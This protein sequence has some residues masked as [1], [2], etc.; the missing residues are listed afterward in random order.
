M[1]FSDT[2]NKLGIIQACE[3]YTNLGDAGISGV[4]QTLKVFTA[5][6]N[7][8]Q[9][10]VWHT[11]FMSYGGWQ[12][13]DSNQTD[14]PAAVATLT[15]GQTSYAIPSGALTVRGVEIKD[16]SNNWTALQPLTEE[17]I[18][19][20]IYTGGVSGR[21][22]SYSNGAMGSFLSTSGTP[23]YYQMVG[24]S[25]RIFPAANYTQASSFKVFFDRGT[26]A[27]AYTDTTKVP[28]FASEYHGI[29]PIG[30]SIEYLM[31]KQ[32]TNPT[33]GSLNARYQEF[34]KNIGDYY[35]LR[36]M[37]MFPPKLRV[38]DSSCESM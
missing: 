1:Q 8:I 5:L 11:I 26:V 24:D 32:P 17:E 2:S 16:A 37:Q 13:D 21:I 3:H 27:F 22:S 30:A 18:R 25:I 36:Y 29:L 14:L 33:L 15:S 4:T 19:D 23:L 9:R 31:V 12:F 6:I 38:R 28:G 34:Q 10:R 35:A 20:G 7:E